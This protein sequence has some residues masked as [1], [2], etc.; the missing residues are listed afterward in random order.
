MTTLCSTP[1][2]L[3]TERLTCRR[4]GGFEQETAKTLRGKKASRR[5]HSSSPPAPGAHDLAHALQP[6]IAAVTCWLTS[7]PR[8]I[9]IVI[10]FAVPDRGEQ[11]FAIVGIEY[12]VAEAQ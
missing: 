3:F 7:P 10:P 5:A 11:S 2:T 4:A 8:R 9:H 6:E 12:P 1:I